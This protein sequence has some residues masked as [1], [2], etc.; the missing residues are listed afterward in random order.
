VAPFTTFTFTAQEIDLLKTSSPLAARFTDGTVTFAFYVKRGAAVSPIKLLDVDASTNGTQSPVLDTVPPTLFGLGTSGNVV[1]SYRSDQRDIVLVGRASETLRAALVSTPLG[2]NVVTMG[3]LPAVTGSHSS[4]LFVSGPVR[5]GVLAAGTPPV[6]YTL[7]IYDRALNTAASAHGRVVQVGQAANGSRMGL[8]TNVHVEVFNATTLAPVVGATVYVHEN[9]TGFTSLVDS[10]QT[11]SNGRVTLAPALVGE[12]IVTVDA[13]SQG[14][15][16]FT[17]DGIPTDSVS[18]PLRPNALTGANVSGAVSTTDPNFGLYM[19]GV[20]DTRFPTPGE[21]Q[22]PT[23]SCSVSTMTQSLVCNF[24]PFGINSR[25]IGA[26]TGVVVLE[27]T[28]PLFYSPLTFLKGFSLTLPMPPA[29]PGSTQTNTL[30]M[31]TS[32]DAG[33]LDPEERPIDVSP[34]VL[35]TVNWPS[36][37]G[38]PRVRVEGTSPGIPRDVTVGRGIAF[39]DALPPNTWAVRAAYPGSVDGIADAMGDALGRFVKSQTIDADLLLRAEVIDAAGNRGGVRPRLSML[40]TMLVAPAAPTPG[41]AP[42]AFN[43]DTLDFSFPD[44]LPDALGE[45]GIY[46]V[47]LTDGAGFTWRIWRLDQA[48]SAG[49]DAVVHLPLIGPGGTLPLATGDLGARISAFAWPMFD[50]ASFLWSDVE[51]EFEHFAHTTTVTVTPP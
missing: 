30:V 18:I 46:R 17:F 20:G 5:V 16:L 34:V 11:D 47:V 51:R 22:L 14:L 26:Q 3:E 21:T 8:F 37:V 31:G 7:T 9:L 38:A 35:S 48:D 13:T 32:L 15:E 23:G 43:T 25:E 24:G 12:T 2:D 39:N 45:G 41:P 27:P 42:F 33:T 40:G 29:D 49:P 28:N 6:P 19:K 10:G 50:P 4:G 44:V 36:I 1:I